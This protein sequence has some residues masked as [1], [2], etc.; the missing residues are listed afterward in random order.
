[1]S[2]LPLAPED[3]T[4]SVQALRDFAV[5]SEDLALIYAWNQL[6]FRLSEKCPNIEFNVRPASGKPRAK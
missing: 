3:V 2:K 6:A 4:D 5:E 1:M